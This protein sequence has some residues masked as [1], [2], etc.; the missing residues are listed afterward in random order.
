MSRKKD[1]K[2]GPQSF[3]YAVWWLQE[4]TRDI[5]LI[6][7][8]GKQKGDLIREVFLIFLIKWQGHF[9]REHDDIHGPVSPGE[10]VRS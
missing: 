5:S 9:N 10:R 1:Q 2:K 6:C 4:I 8:S 3:G 7:Y